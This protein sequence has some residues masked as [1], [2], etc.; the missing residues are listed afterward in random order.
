MNAATEV[1]V[2]EM[3]GEAVVINLDNSAP[4]VRFFTT[5]LLTDDAAAKT[6][7]LEMEGWMNAAPEAAYFFAMEDG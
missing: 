7:L 5:T 6:T 2:P 1:A 3:E 4:K